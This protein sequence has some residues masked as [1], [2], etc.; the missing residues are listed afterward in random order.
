MTDTHTTDGPFGVGDIV[1]LKETYVGRPA[2]S[3]YEV[4]S[5]D[6]IAWPLTGTE[7]RIATKAIDGGEH[8]PG[9]DPSFLFEL[10]KRAQ[11][12]LQPGDVVKVDDNPGVRI[13]TAGDSRGYVSG[14]FHGAVAVVRRAGGWAMPGCVE[15][16]LKDN[17]GFTNEIHPFYLTLADTEAAGDTA[18]KAGAADPEDS[19]IR[20]LQGTVDNLRHDIGVM[21]RIL[22]EE[23][24]VRD[25]CQEYDD[26]LD[27]INDAV[28]AF[29][30]TPRTRNFTVEVSGSINFSTTIQVEATNAD[31]ARE[32][33]AEMFSTDNLSADD[34]DHYAVNL[35]PQDDWDAESD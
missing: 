25:W 17:P 29:Q 27:R 1:R 6:R 12:P 33:A 3:L 23:A 14:E 13:P 24:D 8:L 2:G 21:E 18:D 15:V 11:R 26:I 35:D 28:S 9:L 20:M 19:K 7:Q 22:T 4:T 31:D 16:A 5:V 34:L 30:L 32:A 10:V